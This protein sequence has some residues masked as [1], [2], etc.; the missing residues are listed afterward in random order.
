MRGEVLNDIIATIGDDAA[1]ALVQAFG[2][3]TVAMGSGA[4][5]ELAPVVGIDAALRLV[6]RFSP[7]SLDVPRGS[8]WREA[9]RNAELVECYAQGETQCN[10][11]L[12]FN[13]TERRIRQIIAAHRRTIHLM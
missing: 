3:V 8:R 4:G 13:L 11:A 5:R 1:L 7:G 6:K 10:L 2:G 12:R 9:L